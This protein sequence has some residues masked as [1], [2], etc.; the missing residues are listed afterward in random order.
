L[1]AELAEQGVVLGV[2][3]SGGWFRT[4][5]E[6]AGVANRIGAENIFPTVHSGVRSFRERTKGQGSNGGMMKQR[7]ELDHRK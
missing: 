4:V 1:R 2:A 3:R 5:L 7:E 6:L